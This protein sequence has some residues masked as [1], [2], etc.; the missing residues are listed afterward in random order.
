MTFV[1][2]RA[3]L[4]SAAMGRDKPA[5]H[6]TA[7]TTGAGETVTIHR[8][9]PAT[10]TTLTI[11]WGDGTTTSVAAGVEAAQAHVYAAAGTYAIRVENARNIVQINL[12]D[13][14]LSGFNSAD[15]AGSAITYFS[16]YTLGAA[17]ASRVTT[18]DMASWTPEYWRLSS[19]P[20]GGTYSIDSADMAS[21]TPT[22][23]WLS[24][25]PAGTYTVDSADM[26][27]WTPTYWYLYSMPAGTLTVTAA[28]N[29]NGWIRPSEFRF[30]NL[31]LNQ[32]QVDAILWGLY[33]AFAGKTSTGGTLNLGGSGDTANAAPSG[34]FQAASA[35]PVSVAT[36]G[37]EVAY[38]LL[39]DTCGVSTKHWAT[40]TI[41]A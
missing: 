15:L 6:L 24:S 27:S 7:T 9:T 29:F 30:D 13:S 25:M 8:V 21:W 37:K 38:E 31:T 34:T 36:D 2:R 12:H 20:A 16:C 35:C 14:K 5:L 11:I 17:A 19:M 1:L 32:T 39:N 41:N 23:W 10:G 40:V 22:D 28:A 3:L 33:G 18:A 26:A 4:A